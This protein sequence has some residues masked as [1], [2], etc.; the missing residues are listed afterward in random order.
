MTLVWCFSVFTLVLFIR[1]VE[2]KQLLKQSIKIKWKFWS[3]IINFSSRDAN[4]YSFYHGNILF[5]TFLNVSVF[6]SC[7]APN[8]WKPGCNV[9]VF[10]IL[11]TAPLI[12]FFWPSTQQ[13]NRMTEI[14]LAFATRPS[15]TLEVILMYRHW[16]TNVKKYYRGNITALKHKVLHTGVTFYT[17]TKALCIKIYFIDTWTEITNSCLTLHWHKQRECHSLCA[18]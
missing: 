3:P 11:Q 6:L 4:G 10:I 14:S 15:D 9:V 18:W 12:S 8:M 17:T 5:I 7:S 16:T 13:V 2:L 1:S